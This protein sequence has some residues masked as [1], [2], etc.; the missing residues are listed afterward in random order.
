MHMFGSYR[1]PYPGVEV[2]SGAER[3]QAKAES[4]EQ[5]LDRALV[6]MEA[7]WTLLRE[8]LQV[9]D[10]ELAK[11]IVEVDESDGVLDG[12]VRRP[13]RSCPHCNKT[14]PGR[15]SRCLYCGGLVTPEPFA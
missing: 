10:E 15:F 1:P 12:R 3:A 14:I 5:R 4:V 9:T 6:T 8:R 13:P 7:M 2:T 11:R